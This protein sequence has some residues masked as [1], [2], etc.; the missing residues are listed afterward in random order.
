M[1]FIKWFESGVSGSASGS[2][3]QI[4]LPVALILIFAKLLSIILAKFKIPQVIGFLLAGLL[5]GTLKFIPNSSV[6]NDYTMQGIEILA[7]FGVVMIL[8]S[9]GLE[10]DLKQIKAVGFA[11]V[12]ITSLG[13]IVPMGLGFLV[14]FLFRNYA[15]LDPNFYSGLLS[16]GINPIYSDLYY[17][18]ILSATSVSITVATLKEMGK[19][20][21]K[22][23][24]AI[25][26]AAI[27]DD[28][29]GIILLS[30]IISLSGSSTGGSD[31]N[32]LGYIITSCGGTVSGGLS[33]LVIILNMAIFFGVSFGVSFI[34]KAIFN[35]IGEKHP[36]HIR[37]PIFGLA[38]CFLWAYIAQAYFQIADITGGYIAGLM[39]SSTYDKKYIDHR[40]ETTA[41]V[42]FVPIFFASV[43]L[44]MYQANLNFSDL[45]FVW[46]GLIWIFVG[47]LGKV[48]GAGSGALMCKFKMRESVVVGIGMM[49]R[50]EVLIVTAQT[51]VDAGL[52]SSE[53]IPFTLGLILISSFITPLL[54]KNIFKN[55]NNDISHPS[56]TAPN[57]A[58]PSNDD[59][60]ISAQPS[61]PSK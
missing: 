4:L 47:L 8:F 28:I 46:F 30:L 59:N 44:K 35:H 23:G 43:A 49:A 54:L 11:S 31:F 1:D 34:V 50:A 10:T 38:F 5:V 32:L 7:K 45:T 9:A 3:Y 53:I 15:G 51:G 21:T 27:L 56:G 6:I 20:E 22:V 58:L 19:L 26:A 48:L 37:T 42:F 29:I 12:V 17:G 60:S 52:V 57:V 13:V 41:D 18:V 33:V 61:T 25:V 16:Q 36:H 55:P 24:N 39:L 40:T 14:A 2:P